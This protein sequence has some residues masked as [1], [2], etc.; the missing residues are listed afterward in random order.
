MERLKRRFGR[1]LDTVS[2]G[3]GHVIGIF[4]VEGTPRGHLQL[5]DAGFMRVSS[6]FIPV[7]SS[8]EETVA[9]ALVAAD[10]DFTKP[11]RLEMGDETLSG[12]VLPDFILYDTAARRCYMEVFG[13]QGR[14]D[15][16]VRKLEKRQVYDQKGVMLWDWDLSA[17]KEMPPLPRRVDRSTGPA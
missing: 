12:K 16:D 7:E 17:S 3:E 6:R 2:V 13:V 8:Y 14:E 10:R 4:H 9:D 1:A 15:Y 5:I 11:I